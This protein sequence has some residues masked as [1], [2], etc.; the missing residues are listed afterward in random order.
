MEK[1]LEETR[2]D[3]KTRVKTLTS[4]AISHSR[5]GSVF[6]V[7]FSTWFEGALRKTDESLHR[8]G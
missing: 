1:G 4:V 6:L 3:S 2:L 5:R 7:F 8:E